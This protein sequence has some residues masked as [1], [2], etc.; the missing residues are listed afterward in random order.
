[1]PKTRVQ[2]K[3]VLDKSLSSRR[4]SRSQCEKMDCQGKQEQKR[5]RNSPKPML[6]GKLF[7]PHFENIH[8]IFELEVERYQIPPQVI[9]LI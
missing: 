7:E 8:G 1:M 2:G 5:Q 3:T 6:F 4:K 9:S